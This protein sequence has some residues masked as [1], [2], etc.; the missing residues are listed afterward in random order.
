MK[1]FL[2]PLSLLFVLGLSACSGS[3]ATQDP[4]LETQNPRGSDISERVPV[5]AE[6]FP[7][8]Q[9]IPS[10]SV[11]V[12]PTAVP[13]AVT[14]PPITGVELQLSDDR[15]WIRDRVEAIVSLYNISQGGRDWLES[16][17]IRQMVGRPGWFGSLG[18]QHW[19]GVGQAVPHSIL[20]EI[21]HSYYGTFPVSGRPELTWRPQSGE[22]A[23]SAME[24]YDQ[25][26]IAFM[27][28]PPDRYEPLRDRFRNLPNLSREVDPDLFHFGEADLLY[29]TG[30]SLALIPPILRKYFDRFLG[31]GGFKT[32]EEA[33]SWYLGLSAEDKGSAEVYVGIA[34][35]PLRQYRSLKPSTVTRIPDGVKSLLE[36]EERQR[37]VDF[38]QQ[39]DLIVASEFSLVDAANVDRSFQ[40]WRD[41]LREM[42][43]L[44]KKHPRILGD[45]GERGPLLEDALD[46]VL[47]GEKL[48]LDLQTAFFRDRLGDTFFVNFA[49]LL[50]SQVLMELYG[51]S[52]DGPALRSVGD[53]VGQ[54]S[55]KLAR[56][57]R[58][59]DA[60]LST[61]RTDL[62]KGAGELEG[63]L[64]GLSDDQ[65]EKDLPVILDMM[66]DV[67][68]VLAR[69]L[70]NRMSDETILRALKNK[71]SAILSNALHPERLLQ[72]LRITS[73]HSSDEIVQGL[74]TLFEENSGNFQ[75]DEPFSRSAYRV[76]AD[77]GTTDFEAGL[78]ILKDSKLPIRDFITAQPAA[79]VKILASD[80]PEA[81]GLLAVPQ[82][83]ARS[84]EGILHGLI[85]V[86]PGLAA[87]L[88]GEMDRQGLQ[89]IV[90]GS[91][92][93]FAYDSDRIQ[94]APGLGV[95]LEK[96][97]RFLAALL[98]D[99]GSGWL[100][101]RMKGAAMLYSSHVER[102]DVDA[103]FLEA[104]QRTLTAVTSNLED[105]EAS[106][107]LDQ[108][109]DRVFQ[110]PRP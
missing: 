59:V 57:A 27:Y 101:S 85:Q 54:F 51:R 67:D 53:V 87:N 105:R 49:V 22:R 90:M 68:R 86:D 23:G 34:H 24:Q 62:Q 65:Q 20:H 78:T 74:K 93:V 109:V 52:S 75:I 98:K 44:H 31:G 12:L 17:D 48:P 77:V 71:P 5:H 60:L 64:N 16:Y 35:L 2:G 14:T 40:F 46:A 36:R 88:V 89:D 95:S 13:L 83:Y 30:A 61:G 25:D 79:S 102:G 15:D 108:I 96:D 1:R 76:V 33:I 55:R 32:W 97:G 66:R 70:I 56:Y 7:A 92:I 104:Y 28:Q 107:E 94:A 29:T 91:L 103:D 4:S 8:D 9:I 100:E 72:A 38:A 69:V 99:N 41:Y 19:A 84:P 26:L 80:L 47:E 42:L 43:K 45:T 10:P 37:L 106:G 50:P 81:A 39:F 11:A 6:G 18:N 58:E 110:G 63:F 73:H 82:G 21:S 3:P